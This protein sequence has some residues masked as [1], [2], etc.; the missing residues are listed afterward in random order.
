M[1]FHH[2]A[3]LVNEE[4]VSLTNSNGGWSYQSACES[5]GGGGVVFQNA[6]R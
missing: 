5:A 3:I 1:I 2:I 4:A 6:M